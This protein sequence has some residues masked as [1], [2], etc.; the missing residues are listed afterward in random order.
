MD[1]WLD[2]RKTYRQ[3]HP[4][5]FIGPLREDQYDHLKSVTFFVDPDQLSVL[6]LG[7]QYHS[8]PTDPPPVLA[9]FGSG[10]MQLVTLFQDLGIP[11]AVIGATDIAMRKHLPPDVL[12]FTVSKPMFKQLCELDEKSF[13]HKPF[14]RNL[15]EARGVAES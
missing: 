13:L 10:C 15:R 2:H 8:A 1:Q 4:N 9:P 14:W 11:Q 3:E 5:I 12:A 7:A 6:M